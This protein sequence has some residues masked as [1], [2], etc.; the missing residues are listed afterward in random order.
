[1]STP[2]AN[3]ASSA[4]EAGDP[5]PIGP[6]LLIGADGMLGRAWASLLASANLPYTATTIADLDLTDKRSIDRTIDGRWRTVINGAAWTDVDRAETELTA[7]MEVNAHGPGRL[8]ERCAATG[9]LLVHYSTDYV[10]DGTAASPYPVG[11]PRR[12]SGA[13]ARSKSLGEERVQASGA[14]HLIIRT[15]WLYAP[16]GKNFVRTIARL[17]RERPELKVV[18]DQRGRPT[19]AEGLARTSLELIRRR[20]RGIYHATDAGE[21]TWFEFAREI[22]A[23]IGDGYAE[24]VK[25][26]TTAEFPRPAPRPAYSV[27]DIT[28]TERAV[29]P[30]KD[31]RAALAEVMPRLE[32]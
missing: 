1:M 8:A 32:E 25:P 17:V 13:Y 20:R 23:S 31:W 30:M 21:C 3:Q 16:W 28:E 11:H 26:C 7:A 14:D 22:A 24:R 27:L 29:G 2:P 4:P 10:F 19:S 6:V 15:S 18:N 5:A 9:S 12:P